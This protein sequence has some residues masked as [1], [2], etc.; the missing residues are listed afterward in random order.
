MTTKQQ[1]IL[2]E[3]IFD[4]LPGFGDVLTQEV[5]LK[6][7]EMYPT[8]IDVENL[9]EH[10]LAHNGGYEFVNEAERDFN[11]RN[12]SDSKTVSVNPKTGKAEIVGVENKIGS[13]RITVFNP[14]SPESISYLYIPSDYLPLLSRECYGVNAGK[15]RLCITW[16]MVR[17][18]RYKDKKIGYF[19]MYEKFRLDTF[20]ELAQMSDEKFYQLNP[21]LQLH[22]SLPNSDSECLTKID[23]NEQLPILYIEDSAQQRSLDFGDTQPISPCEIS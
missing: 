5:I 7:T 14:I 1:I 21:H 10:A 16:S 8:C 19:N 4:K 3:L 22:I 15:K 11:D 2:R 20:E 13:I 23:P 6:I 9:T 17:P 18:K 12:D